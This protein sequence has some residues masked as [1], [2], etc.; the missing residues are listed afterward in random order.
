MT[1]TTEPSLR[2]RKIV[3]L[4]LS[5]FFVFGFSNVS[6]L[7]PVYYRQIGVT[8]E[9]SIGWLVAMFYI[10]SVASRLFLA[11]VVKALGFRKLFVVAGA[12]SIVCSAGIAL[13]GG[14]FWAS[15][16]ARGMLGIA[17]SMF[18]IGLATYQALA[19]PVRERGKA[20]SLIMAGGL[21]PMMTAVPFA[22]F[23]LL[24]KMSTLYILVPLAFCIVAALITPAI[25][26]LDEFKPEEGT[27]GKRTNPLRDIKECLTIPA[28]RFAALSMFLFS[29]TDATSAFMASMT[30]HYGLMA[31]LFLSSNAVVGVCVR[32]F[33]ASLL[34]RIPRWAMSGPT[35]LITSGTLLLASVNPTE[36]TLILLGLIFGIGMG[37]G[38]PL[39][40]ALVSDSVP[41]HLQPQAVSFSWFLMGFNFAVF[42]LLMG[43]IGESAGAVASFRIVNGLAFLGISALTVRRWRM[44]RSGATG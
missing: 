20:F 26:G 5:F 4:A 9:Q 43:W 10:S 17:S 19:F 30:S 25:P 7:L 38:F 35:I 33:C 8:S 42:P 21:A 36:K 31:S 3:F 11:D 44:R 27:A 14:S 22:D 32:L 41:Q 12:L 37:F 28:F 15:L 2:L 6:Y 29:A 23:L 13:F 24:R 34:D 40:L 18:Q 1:V 16:I 39:H